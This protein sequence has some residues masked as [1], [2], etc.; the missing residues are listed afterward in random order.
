[1]PEY[2]ILYNSWKNYISNDNTL[3]EI[4]KPRAGQILNWISKSMPDSYSFDNLFGNKMRLVVSLK[5]KQKNLAYL[6]QRSF[7]K[8]LTLVDYYSKWKYDNESLSRG[9][10]YRVN[11]PKDFG[12]ELNLQRYKMEKPPPGKRVEKKIGK[13][14]RGMDNSKNKIIS[15]ALKEVIEVWEKEGDKKLCPQGSVVISRHSIDVARMSDFKNLKSCHTPGSSFYKCAIKESMGNAPVA[16]FVSKKQLDKLFSEKGIEDIGELDQEEILEDLDRDIQGLSPTSRIRLRKFSGITNDG[17]PFELAIPEVRV[18]GN[19]VA[20]F[21]ET[22]GDWALNNQLSAISTD[23]ADRIILKDKAWRE[24]FIEAQ[25]KYQSALETD[26]E[27]EMNS[28]KETM[29]DIETRIAGVFPNTEDHSFRWGGGTYIDTTA[30]NLFL[31]FFGIQEIRYEVGARLPGGGRDEGRTV[32]AH[33]RNIFSEDF[34]KHII[35]EYEGMD[36]FESDEQEIQG[37]LGLKAEDMNWE[38]GSLYIKSGIRDQADYSKATEDYNEE[39]LLDYNQMWPPEF[40]RQLKTPEGA[41][42]VADIV[43]MAP[44]DILAGIKQHNEMISS[45]RQMTDGLTKF[46]VEIKNIESML[47]EGYVDSVDDIIKMV[48]KNSYRF[49]MRI[50][51]WMGDIFVEPTRLPTLGFVLG[52]KGNPADDFFINGVKD[53]I[54]SEGGSKNI[55]QPPNER[56]WNVG[57]SMAK[58]QLE[59]GMTSKGFKFSWKWDKEDRELGNDAEI[60]IIFF[61]KTHLDSEIADLQHLSIE[62]KKGYEEIITT[63]LRLEKKWHTVNDRINKLFES[64]K[65]IETEDLTEGASGKIEEKRSCR[66]KKRPPIKI[67]ISRNIKN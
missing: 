10:F 17:L 53:I 11:E 22:I 12:P 16:Y 14:L 42:A 15:S 58:H 60:N 66:G 45:L 28:A 61:F 34:I 47:M 18:Y 39:N 9:S 50:G 54:E 64:E 27:D 1:M 49:H 26:D 65:E 3:N 19:Y 24:D 51:G 20:H 44:R 21:S 38:L 46:I 5:F 43:G 25:H 57:P 67:K 56:G 36:E 7:K 52:D 55:L 33:S 23:S 41:E 31:N 30:K 13:V 48:Q 8:I 63:L 40:Y 6:D 4:S 62:T 37:K 29:M 59:P 32:N 2:N 35:E